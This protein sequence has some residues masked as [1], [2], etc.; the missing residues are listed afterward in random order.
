MPR[1]YAVKWR[2]QECRTHMFS[3]FAPLPFLCLLST[4]L[5]YISMHGIYAHCRVLSLYVSYTRKGA[6]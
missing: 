2:H 6:S 4:V 5:R 1:V 3:L